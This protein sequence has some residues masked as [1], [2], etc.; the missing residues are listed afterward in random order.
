MGADEVRLARAYL[1]RVAEPPAA[2]VTRFVAEHGPEVAAELVR[3]AR[4]PTEVAR[5]TAARREFDRAREDV[6]VAARIGARL[7]TPEDEEWPA[8]AF[9]CFELC[10]HEHLSTPLALWVRGPGQLGP[11]TERSAAIVG[12]RASSGYGD[13]VAN[14]FGYGVARAGCTVISGAAFGIDGAAHR[15]ALAAEGATVAVLACGPAFGAAA[16]PDRPAGRSRSG[17]APRPRRRPAG[18]E[19]GGR[20]GPRAGSAGGGG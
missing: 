17:R 1:L 11:L 12:A 18:G 19:Y 4:V 20:A 7:V 5:E 16:G 3:A 2:A 9:H 14:S 8:A 6:D 13:H 15:G 10:G